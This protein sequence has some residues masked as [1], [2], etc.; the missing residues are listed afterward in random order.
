MIK[1]G[2]CV[3]CKNDLNGPVGL[4]R[5]VAKDGTWADVWWRGRYGGSFDSWSKRMKTKE[6]NVVEKG[7]GWVLN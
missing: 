7:R 1:R 5:R 3:V 2:D 6:L 4:I